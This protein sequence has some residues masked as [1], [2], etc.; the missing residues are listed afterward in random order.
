MG[1]KFTRLVMPSC[2]PKKSFNFK[3][4]K[5]NLEEAVFYEDNDSLWTASD[6]D[7]DFHTPRMNGVSP[8]SSLRIKEEANTKKSKTSYTCNLTSWEAKDGKRLL[9]PP[10]VHGEVNTGTNEKLGFCPGSNFRLRVGPDYPNNGKKA[11]SGPAMY[12]LRAVDMVETKRKV[13]HISRFFDRSKTKLDEK[14][15]VLKGDIINGI[16]RFFVVTY[17]LPSYKPSMSL[18]NAAVTDGPGFTVI[19]LFVL[20]KKWLEAEMACGKPSGAARVL[21]RYCELDCDIEDKKRGPNLWK[22]IVSVVNYQDL[23]LSFYLNNYIRKYNAKPWLSRSPDMHNFKGKDYYEVDIDIHVYNYFGL[24]LMYE[25]QP[26]VPKLVCDVGFTVQC[27]DDDEMPEVV[28]GCG[29]LSYI[30]YEHDCLKV[31]WDKYN[32]PEAPHE[33]YKSQS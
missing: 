12:N 1:S 5:V 11:P 16:P 2:Y 14:E 30:S 29:R 32:A 17:M 27:E 20:S 8:A 4:T 33:E 24:R 6:E 13:S 21:R 19:F 3:D 31:D 10:V 15:D 26:Y 7:G 9:N 25:L 22:N 18:F 23:G 28:L